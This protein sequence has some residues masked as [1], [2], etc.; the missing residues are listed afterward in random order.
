MKYAGPISVGMEWISSHLPL[1]QDLVTGLDTDTNGREH[2]TR[3]LASVKEMQAFA[4]CQGNFVSAVQRSGVASELWT[5]GAQAVEGLFALRLWLKEELELQ[6]F[7]PLQDTYKEYTLAASKGLL[8]DAKAT[9][10]RM[11]KI[12]HAASLFRPIF[13]GLSL[14][15]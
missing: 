8:N 10:S 9:A 6:G 3:V 5:N 7:L 11:R 12:V 14:K 1:F 15:T 4:L 2:S 13:E